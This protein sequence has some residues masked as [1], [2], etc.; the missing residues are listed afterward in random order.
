MGPSII[1][2]NH[3]SACVFIGFETYIVNCIHV[4]YNKRTSDSNAE[5]TTAWRRMLAAGILET[6][7]LALNLLKQ[8]WGLGGKLENLK[9]F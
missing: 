6:S 2:D 4:N 5:R 1:S 8:K 3:I 9:I 7:G